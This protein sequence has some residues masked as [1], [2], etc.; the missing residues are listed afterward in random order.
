MVWSNVLS[1]LLQSLPR[2]N[3]SRNNSGVDLLF[4]PRLCSSLNSNLEF[5]RLQRHLYSDG[6]SQQNFPGFGSD[7]LNK[8]KL[9]VKNTRI[10]HVEKY[11][12]SGPT[13]NLG[14]DRCRLSGSSA[15]EFR[16]D[17]C[18]STLR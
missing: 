16:I 4:K 10:L 9:T 17:V 2:I 1:T 13:R 12:G 5:C 6:V 14:S 8:T 7:L 18:E 15:I 11:D 3:N